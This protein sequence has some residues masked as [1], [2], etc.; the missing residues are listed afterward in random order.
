[1]KWL[2]WETVFCSVHVIK[3]SMFDSTIHLDFLKDLNTSNN[4]TNFWLK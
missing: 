2:V 1:M 3:I 4:G